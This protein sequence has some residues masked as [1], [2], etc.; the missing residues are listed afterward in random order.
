MPRSVFLPPNQSRL[1]SRSA[2]GMAVMAFLA[3]ANESFSVAMTFAL[4]VVDFSNPLTSKPAGG[5]VPTS[6]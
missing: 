5:G 2:S 3:W 4:S 1:L 6:L